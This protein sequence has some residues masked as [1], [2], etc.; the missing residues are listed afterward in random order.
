MTLTG[1]GTVVLVLVKALV[2]EQRDEWLIGRQQT[3]EAWWL[4]AASRIS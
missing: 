4:M 2:Q 3:P 1:M